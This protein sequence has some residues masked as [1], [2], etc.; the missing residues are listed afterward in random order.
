L[1]LLKFFD[2][3]ICGDDV[4]NPKPE[5]EMLLKLLKKLNKKAEEALFIGDGERDLIASKRAGID[6][7]LV[8]WGFSNY[9]RDREVVNDVKSLREKIINF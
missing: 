7:I 2:E 1:G 8:N 3:V 5:P 4:I 9:S 6:F